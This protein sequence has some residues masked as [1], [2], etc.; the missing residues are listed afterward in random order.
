LQRGVR[1]FIICESS[2]RLQDSLPGRAIVNQRA[3]TGDQA[4]VLPSRD[5]LRVFSL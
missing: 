3:A 1:L 2:G 5:P 4:A